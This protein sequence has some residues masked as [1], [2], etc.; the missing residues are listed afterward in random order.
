MSLVLQK[1]K[2]NQ[3]LRK[4]DSIPKASSPLIQRTQVRAQPAMAETTNSIADHRQN[5]NVFIPADQKAI[6]LVL[7]EI[8]AESKKQ[9]ELLSKK[10]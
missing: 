6:W 8:L 10:A 5:R 2:Y 3:R 9:T 1:L 7:Q 4:M